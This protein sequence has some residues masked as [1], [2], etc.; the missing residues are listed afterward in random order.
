ML[1]QEDPGTFILGWKF[2]G[3]LHLMIETFLYMTPNSGERGSAT[4]LF[5]ICIFDL[6]NYY[7]FKKARPNTLA[8]LTLF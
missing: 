8:G 1:T 7:M 4:I 2:L 6:L 5:T 3:L